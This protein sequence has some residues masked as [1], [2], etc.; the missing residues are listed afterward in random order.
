V[1]KLSLVSVK[2]SRNRSSMK[3]TQN[4]CCGRPATA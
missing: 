2:N 1:S 3:Y 4:A